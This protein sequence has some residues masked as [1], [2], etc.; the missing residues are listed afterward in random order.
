M[1]IWKDIA[2]FEG[3]YQ[4]SN[5]G[6]IRSLPRVRPHRCGGSRV[7]AGQILKPW[8]VK[9]KQYDGED[10]KGYYLAVTLAFH[11]KDTKKLVHR[12]VAGAFIPNPLNKPYVNHKNGIRNDNVVS[13]LEWSTEKENA[14]HAS[15]N[16]LISKGSRRYC[17]RLT[18]SRIPFIRRRIAVGHSLVKIAED[19]GVSETAIRMIKSGRTWRHV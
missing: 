15:V 2:G 10:G 14:V 5:L 11:Q 16:N 1:E 8:N 3:E 17:A 7:V 12:L 19:E 4:V 13:N 18:K 9:N 6:R